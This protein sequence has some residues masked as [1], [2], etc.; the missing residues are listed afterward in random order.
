[1]AEYE[2]PDGWWLGPIGHWAGTVER[3]ARDSFA[4]T[5]MEAGG[6][7]IWQFKRGDKTVQLAL[8]YAQLQG[9]LPSPGVIVEHV[10]WAHRHTHRAASLACP[11]SSWG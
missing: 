8:S 11:L 5:R 3:L 7:L 6:M 9:D 10:L 1:M 2:L 4:V